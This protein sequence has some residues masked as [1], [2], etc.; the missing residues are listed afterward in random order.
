MRGT[1]Y[2]VSTSVG[3]QEGPVTLSIA[4]D[5]NLSDFPADP[6]LT[7]EALTRRIHAVVTGIMASG[8]YVT[9]SASGGV[10]AVAGI[11]ADSHW[12]HA[13]DEPESSSPDKLLN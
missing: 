10:V 11:Y 9:S 7:Q 1:P 4:L 5:L 8:D 13:D 2:S 6:R 3:D 12:W